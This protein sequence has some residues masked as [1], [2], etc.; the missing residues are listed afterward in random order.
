MRA[1]QR[2]PVIAGDHLSEQDAVSQWLADMAK[3]QDLRTDMKA[4]QSFIT[5]SCQ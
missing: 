4:L 1:P 2:L 3:Y 5:T